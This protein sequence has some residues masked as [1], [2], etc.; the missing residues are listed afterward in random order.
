[1]T[2]AK[3]RSVRCVRASGRL[4]PQPSAQFRAAVARCSCAV[5]VSVP[6]T[7]DADHKFSKASR[8]ARSGITRLET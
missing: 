8:I 5:M 7:A 6:G 1:M 2:M 4:I 3:T